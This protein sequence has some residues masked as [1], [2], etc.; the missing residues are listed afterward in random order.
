MILSDFFPGAQFKNTGAQ[1]TNN[2]NSSR[3]G[4]LLSGRSTESGS[5][6]SLQSLKPGQTLQG[7][8]VSKDGDQVQIKLGDDHVVEAKVDRDMNLQ[9][10]KTMTFEVRSNGQSL[11]LSPLFENT[12]TQAN[13]LKALDMASLPANQTTVTMTGLMMEAGLPVDRSSL[14]QMFREVNHFSE[15]SLSNI[16][17]LHK[18]GLAVNEGNLSQIDSYKNLTHQLVEGMH[19]VLDAVPE[20]MQDMIADGNVEGAARMFQ[21]ML[22]M[23][24]ELQSEGASE[25]SQPLQGESGEMISPDG[26]TMAAETLLEGNPADK[27]VITEDGGLQ[28]GVSEIIP[29]TVQNKEGLLQEN[30]GNVGRENSLPGENISGEVNA[31]ISPQAMTEELLQLVRAGGGDGSTY[32][33]FIQQFADAVQNGSAAEQ[34]R[35][36]Q[37]L[38]QQGL[39]DKDNSFLKGLLSQKDVQRVLTDG[40]SRLWTIEPKDVADPGKVEELYARL[41]RQLNQL[42]HTLE[43]NGQ[44]QSQAFKAV[45]NMTQ[46]ID[47]LQ[48]LNQAYTYV[49]LPLRL[50]QSDAHG[51][52]YVYTNK[53]NLASREGQISALLHLDMENLG[54]VDVYVAM[55]AEKVNTRFYVRDD[56]MLDFLEAHMDLLTERLQ[57]RGYDCSFSM[58]SRDEKTPPQSGLNGLSGEADGQQPK[59][60]AQYAF[61][62]RA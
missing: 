58:Q 61:D 46:N 4:S 22:E 28:T 18:L 15:A 41:N 36:L 21:D 55:Q 1:R 56:E 37:Q 53:R 51:D 23:V 24:G 52:L 38:V 9:P 26:R 3:T 32:A 30:E 60:I 12:A 34:V 7:E 27:V 48:Q 14:Q 33:P 11:T 6:Q 47:F 16:V 35:T 19:A 5:G 50:Q 2:V 17:D 44:E 43:Q 54:P 13:A 10:G 42:S 8:V 40:F 62:V 29:E 59:T 45:T 57:K 31:E 25:S 20:T 49:Q 39:Q